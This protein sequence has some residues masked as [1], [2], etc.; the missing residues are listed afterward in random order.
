MARRHFLRNEA[1]NPIEFDVIDDDQRSTCHGCKA[2]VARSGDMWHQEECP[3]ARALV[4]RDVQDI[5]GDGAEDFIGA[6]RAQLAKE[7]A[8][9]ATRRDGMT[10]QDM[11]VDAYLAGYARAEQGA[12]RIAKTG[13]ARLASEL[14]AWSGD[15]SK[16]EQERRSSQANPDEMALATIARYLRVGAEEMPADHPTRA[17]VTSAASYADSASRGSRLDL[18][19]K[20]EMA[21]LANNEEMLGLVPTA[22][23][24]RAKVVKILRLLA[25]VFVD[26]RDDG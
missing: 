12:L 25:S 19:G 5:T 4:A 10:V 18:Q 20:Y 1:A 7:Y 17:L 3:A 23:I 26:S 8:D 13:L 9:T 15:R 2:Y 21:S 22:L 6:M 14:E 24:P 11:L 16:R